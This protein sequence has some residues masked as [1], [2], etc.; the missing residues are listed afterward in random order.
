[1]TNIPK[2]HLGLVAVSRDCF[3]IELS[4]KRQLRVAQ[5]CRKAGLSVTRIPTV[6]ENEKD[7]LQALEEVRAKGA[8]A[9]V[10]YLGNFGP[11]GPTT[12]LAQKFGG[13]V[14]FAAAAEESGKNLV[15]GRGDAYCGMLN[16]SYN[17]GLRKLKVHVPEYPVGTP[18]EVARMAVEFV[19]VARILLGLRRLKIFAFGPRPQDF[20]AC[21]API[22]PLYDL[23]VEVMENSELDL[24]DIFLQAAG[25]RRV[26]AVAAD[27]ARE[28]GAG[29]AYPDLLV[30]LAQF[31]VALLDFM[32][33]NLGA[34]EYGVFADKCWPSFEKYFG[35]VPCYVNSRLATRG[36][37]VACEVDIYGA[38]SE[39]I[40]ACAT[41]LPATI[42]DINNTV[43]YDMIAGARKTVKGYKPTDLFMGFHCG[44]TPAPCMVAPEM[45]YQLIMHRLME[46]GKEPAITR[47]T[48]EGR[49]RAGGVTIFRL[50]STADTVLRS[51]MA[52]GEVLD[53]DPRSFGGIGVIGI[54]E[55]GRFYRHV[56]IGKRFPHHTA[57]AF[58]PVGKTLWAAMRALGVEDVSFNRPAGMFYPEENPF[59]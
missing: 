6:V 44:N 34:S 8:N 52:E 12:L 43:P 5:E 31:E 35:F 10:I 46:P 20:L 23:G 11:E 4:R 9:L 25:H 55:M 37:P 45:R 58:A 29:N 33:K 17:T 21:N 16:T 26:K 36:I 56:L 39:Y 3:P 53:V 49:I 14:M 59:A 30:K 47:G 28:L 40:C 1:M 7:A 54:K 13:P 27:M 42:L 18:E 22:K 57:V 19:P 41:E 48:L 32:D 2:V 50:Q 24:Y 15:D 51:Y 38:L